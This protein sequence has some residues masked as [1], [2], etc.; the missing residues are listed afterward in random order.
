M[1]CLLGSGPHHAPGGRIGALVDVT[2]AKL[3]RTPAG[4]HTPF[5]TLRLA[6]ADAILAAMGAALRTRDLR[7]SLEFIE[8]AWSLA[9]ARAFTFDT[10]AALGELIPADEIGYSDLDRVRRQVLD[11]VG[12]DQRDD[13]D[14]ADD[15]ELFWG[16]VDTHPIC[17]HQQAYADF[18]AI[19]L[20]DV[21]SRRR[22]VN[23]RIYAEWFR[24]AGFEA[25]LEV[26]ITR[27]TAR[28]R[29]FVLDRATG[30]FSER[31]RAVLELVRPH[32]RRIHEMTDMRRAAASSEPN[33]LDLLTAREFEILELVAAGL[34]N[35][36]IAERLW[37]SPGTV[38]RHLENIYAKLQVTNRTAAV[39][40]LTAQR[41][42]GR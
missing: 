33:D 35:A 41:R 30:D 23:S 31:D 2:E 9:D 5:G 32:L 14:E 13:G 15:D 34:R 6:A 10:L 40:R 3:V 12:T 28:T 36:A 16:I 8:I 42:D 7:A 37:I 4:V 1:G 27:S 11:Y 20:S 26:G 22:L 19:R 29:D 38:K 18:S 25:E 39:T 21:I 17:R 24:P